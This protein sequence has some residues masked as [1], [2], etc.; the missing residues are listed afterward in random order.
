MVAASTKAVSASAAVAARVL[1]ALLRRSR[2]RTIRVPW[3]GVS[4]C[5][6]IAS[7]ALASVDFAVA[8]AAACLARDRVL[9]AGGCS[10]D[11]LAVPE[12]GLDAFEWVVGMM[13]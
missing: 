12:A 4:D 5:K 2:C 7:K 10:T 11:C 3:S 6:S 9:A 13:K 8:L 1:G